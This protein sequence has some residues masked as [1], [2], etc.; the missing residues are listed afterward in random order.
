M[1]ENDGIT[2]DRFESVYIPISTK[3]K[4]NCKV[5]I[6]RGDSGKWYTSYSVQ[7]PLGGEGYAPW[8]KFS[9]KYD[10]RDKAVV[11]GCQLA[12]AA[13]KKRKDSGKMKQPLLTGLDEAIERHTPR[14]PLKPGFVFGWKY[15]GNGYQLYVEVYPK[16]MKP[17]EKPAGYAKC[18]WGVTAKVERA[19]RFKSLPACLEFYRSRHIWPEEVE[20]NIWNG[21]VQFFEVTKAGIRSVQPIEQQSL[22]PGGA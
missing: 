6:A 13:I 15:G 18:S 16:Q 22:F 14:E 10:T 5:T 3:S 8:P 7:L 21:K 11:A 2:A 17:E 12:I 1:E 19:F 20:A 9:K 4:S